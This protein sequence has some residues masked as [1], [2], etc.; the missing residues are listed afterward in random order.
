MKYL[1][2]L[3]R[4][5][6]LGLF[7]PSGPDGLTGSF[8]AEVTSLVTFLVKDRGRR[9]GYAGKW[10]YANKPISLF[11]NQ[12]IGLIASFASMPYPTSAVLY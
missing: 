12:K 9:V 2:F 11:I 6:V 7:G 5:H 4:L 1:Q 10:S 8:V 3:V